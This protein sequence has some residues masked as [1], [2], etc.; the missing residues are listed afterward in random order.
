MYGVED[1][2]DGT[3]EEEGGLLYSKVH[4]DPDVLVSED[5]PRRGR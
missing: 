1:A 2:E 5:S 3:D 4:L